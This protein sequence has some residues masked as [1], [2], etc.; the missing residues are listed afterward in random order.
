MELSRAAA[1]KVFETQF[2]DPVSFFGD[3][4]IWN[5]SLGVRLEA[6]G[7]HGRMGR[8]GA[9]LARMG[10][11]SDREITELAD[12]RIKP[13]A[14]FGVG[15]DI[16]ISGVRVVLGDFEYDYNL[17]RYALTDDHDIPGTFR[18]ADPS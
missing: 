11:I 15:T 14:A 7:A 2:F 6:G 16:V 9:A 12:K 18:P 4:R 3:D 1:G 17:W 13:V 8:Y 10:V 5:L